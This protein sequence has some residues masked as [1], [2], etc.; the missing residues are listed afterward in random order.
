MP[1]DPNRRIDLEAIRAEPP[2]Y[3]V[4]EDV[5]GEGYRVVDTHTNRQHHDLPWVT[6]QQ[7]AGAMQRAHVYD[8]NREVFGYGVQSAATKLRKAASQI[9]RAKVAPTFGHISKVSRLLG[10]LGRAR[11]HKGVALEHDDHLR[12]AAAMYKGHDVRARALA[13]LYK[14]RPEVSTDEHAL[15]ESLDPSAPHIVGARGSATAEDFLKTDVGIASG[16]FTKTK[17]WARA[18]KD[19]E[20]I[21]N[22]VDGPVTFT[23]HSLGGTIAQHLAARHGGDH[24][25]FNPGVGLEAPPDAPGVTYSVDG[26]AVSAVG[27]LTAPSSHDVRRLPSHG[28]TFIGNHLLGGFK[29]VEPAGGMLEP[30]EDADD[31]EEED[32]EEPL[33]PLPPPPPPPEPVDVEELGLEEEWAGLAAAAQRAEQEGRHEQAEALWR[34]ADQLIPPAVPRRR[35]R[36]K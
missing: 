27:H 35:H 13:P 21:M 5:T 32:E 6:A 31:E 4:R 29:T 16:T 30:A 28:A 19:A 3:E 14:Y 9:L 12:A 23:G 2:R 11:R 33:P 10:R 36:Q 22:A 17:R 34:A 1:V 24:V 7:Y 25:G 20:K 18:K 26:D 15:W 8:S